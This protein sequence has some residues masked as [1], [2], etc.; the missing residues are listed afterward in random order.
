VLGGIGAALLT[1]LALLS[2]GAPASLLA[3]L[4]ALSGIAGV[5]IERWLFF[6]EATHTV[7]LYYGRRAD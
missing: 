6:A 1:V 4:A 3:L 5:M 2:S 7:T